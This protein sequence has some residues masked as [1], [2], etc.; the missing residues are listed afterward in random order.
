V[1]KRRPFARAAA[2]RY[3]PVTVK[4]YVHEEFQSHFDS[5]GCFSC[6]CGQVHRLLTR[7]VITGKGALGQSA[8]LLVKTRGAGSVL[9]VLSDENTEA[10]AGAAWKA[11]VK[12][13][14]IVSRVLPARPRPEPAMS[15]IEELGREARA[16]GPDLLVS[17]GSGVISDLVKRVSLDLGIPNWCVATAASVDA[18]TSA[19]SSVHVRGFHNAVPAAVSEAVICDLDV[20]QRSP[21]EMT[22]AG[23]G[24]LLAKFIAHLD[25]SLSRIMTGEHF[26]DVISTAALDSARKALAAA[27]TLRKDPALASAALADAVVTSGFAMQVAGSSRSAASVEHM[28]AHFWE[29]ADA[30]RNERLDLHGILVGTASRAVLR[31][32]RAFYKAFAG[33]K[34]RRD[35][36]LRAFAAEKPWEETLEPGLAPYREKVLEEMERKKMDAGTLERRLARLEESREEILKVAIPALDE[37]AESIDVLE[38]LDYP[39]S[40]KEI[41]LSE[42]LFLL[43]VRNVRLL[44][45]RYSTFDLAWEMGQ[46]SILTEEITSHVMA[47]D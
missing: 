37:L 6:P 47:G 43:P 16:A 31:G 2:N 27:R 18:F 22:L 25:W 10:A 40:L 45:A 17:V 5:Q 29:V 26:C 32:Y 9:W 24:D 28:M 38:S 44:R 34:V 42:E 15:V 3:I 13:A 36:R 21:P 7:S 23:L 19:T 35:E 8:E 30:V 41:G 14:R 20:I 39:F 33:L 1:R 46:E 4:R 12:A 11:G